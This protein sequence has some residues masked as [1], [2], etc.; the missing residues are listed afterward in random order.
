LASFEKDYIG[1]HGQQNIK[2]EPFTLPQ[3]K[4]IADITSPFTFQ[5]DYHTVRSKVTSLSWS[6]EISLGNATS[7]NYLLGPSVEMRNTHCWLQQFKYTSRKANMILTLS[8]L[9]WWRLKPSATLRQCRHIAVTPSDSRMM[10]RLD[11]LHGT[12]Y[13]LCNSTDTRFYM[14]QKEP[15]GA[16]RTSTEAC[17][18]FT[19]IRASNCSVDR[20]FW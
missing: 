17:Y 12:A 20:I 8:Q 18:V 4:F 6:G 5:Y 16:L 2:V 9:C 11:N 13:H 1:M 19:E 7:K 14:G 10:I 15:G 3:C